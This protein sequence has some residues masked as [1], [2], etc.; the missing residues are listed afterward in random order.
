MR[1]PKPKSAPGLLLYGATVASVFLFGRIVWVLVGQN[2]ETVSS[3]KGYDKFLLARWSDIMGW[4]AENGFWLSLIGAALIGVT[5]ALWAYV[6]LQPSIAQIQLDEPAKIDEM[7]ALAIPSK[8]GS[9]WAL[10]LKSISAKDASCAFA[11]ISADEYKFSPK[12]KAIYNQIKQ[13]V[14]SGLILTSK[15]L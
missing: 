11:G 13:S 5:L 9:A 10:G 12:A 8:E 15:S 2:I 7:T 4:L 1:I 14:D 3:D 6:I